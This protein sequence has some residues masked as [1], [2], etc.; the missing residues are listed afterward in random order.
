MFCST[1]CELQAFKRYHKYEC[2]VMDQLLKSA[3]I[4]MPL[5]QL[6]IALSVFDGSI[7]EL[8]KFF[9]ENENSPVT[10]F[11]FNLSTQSNEND[12]NLL[13]C[14]R[15]MIKS[16]E[17]FDL[18]EFENI[19]KNHNQLKEMWLTNQDFIKSFLQMQCQISD[20]NVHGIFSGSSRKI[21]N[22]DSN[23]I[24][25]SLQHAIGTGTLLF[26]A[27]TNHSCA[28]NVFRVYVDGKVVYSVCR[29]IPKGSQLF[30][31]YK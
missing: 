8:Q 7:N 19:L 23:T 14:M 16:S 31:C 11:D 5:K 21:E 30:D 9:Q 10:V 4:H 29:P 18:S 12:K 25:S 22:L 17:P 3:S 28:N 2:S 13:L 27:L 24:F 15:S 26:G 1:E 20:L 6:F